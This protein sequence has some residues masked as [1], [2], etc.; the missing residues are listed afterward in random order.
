MDA[1]V[2]MAGLLLGA[3]S[4]VTQAQPSNDF[5]AVYINNG[6]LAAGIGLDGQ[7]GIG[8]TNYDAIGRIT[9][10]TAQGARFTTDDDNQPL[11]FAF[12][13]PCGNFGVVTVRVE[14]AEETT[15][16]IWGS[17]DG[18]W[19]DGVETVCRPKRSVYDCRTMAA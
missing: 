7:V 1:C 15:N 14:S 3:L 17:E 12:P 5:R 10:G 19:V 11:L 16:V 9:L 18:D 8:G 2:L 4:A 13:Y 6:I